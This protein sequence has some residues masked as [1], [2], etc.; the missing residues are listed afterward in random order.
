MYLHVVAGAGLFVEGVDVLG[1]E[2]ER[3]VALR[4]PGIQL[5][6]GT[7]SRIG[8]GLEYLVESIDVPAP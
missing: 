1:D 8:T 2:Q 3:T 6:Q 4:V 7:M 5:Y